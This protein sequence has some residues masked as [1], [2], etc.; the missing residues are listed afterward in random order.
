MADGNNT[1]TATTSVVRNDEWIHRDELARFIQMAVDQR[2]DQREARFSELIRRAMEDESYSDKARER[3]AKFIKRYLEENPP[4]GGSCSTS[5]TN[6]YECSYDTRLS[7]QRIVNLYRQRSQD[8]LIDQPLAPQE[9]KTFTVP[10]Y[11]LGRVIE[12]LQFRPKMDNGG[13]PDDIKVTI[14]GEDGVIW[15]AFSGGKH[16]QEACCLLEAFTHDCIGWGEGFVIELYHR[17]DVGD[18]AMLSA[19]VDFEYLFPGMIPNSNKYAGWCFP[20]G[21]KQPIAPNYPQQKPPV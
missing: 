5:A 8:F 7:Y 14:R 13:N 15:A 16:V 3:L 11:P 2:L 21:N 17:G 20:C 4:C 19:V 6:L 12:Y 18:P 10:A 1:L 9:T